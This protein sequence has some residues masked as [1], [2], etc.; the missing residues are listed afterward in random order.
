M[1]SARMGEAAQRVLDT[2][3]A[4]RGWEARRT[5]GGTR[6]AAARVHRA[7]TEAGGETEEEARAAATEWEVEAAMRGVTTAA[8]ALEAARAGRVGAENRHTVAAA[9]EEACAHREAAAAAAA[10]GARR[11]VERRRREGARR[12]RVG[13]EPPPGN[14]SQVVDGPQG[15]VLSCPFSLEWDGRRE[16]KLLGA[17]CD[18]Y[19][20]LVGSAVRAPHR[21]RLAMLAAT[22]TWKLRGGGKMMLRIAPGYPILPAHG[23]EIAAAVR[24]LAE[25]AARGPLWLRSECAA[26]ERSHVDGLVTI[27]NGVVALEGAAAVERAEAEEYRAHRE[28]CTARRR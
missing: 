13:E 14:D 7:G 15:G 24:G 2:G 26:G 19:E 4:E 9:A 27:V 28:K 23:H 25:R 20:V 21:E 11:E 17:A 10:K 5:E 18:A 22:T 16:E 12:G 8:S 6:A 1:S 3:G